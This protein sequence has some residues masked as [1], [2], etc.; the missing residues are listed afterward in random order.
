MKVSSMSF[1]SAALKTSELLNQ[2]TKRA[3]LI[4]DSEFDRSRIKRLNSKLEHPLI[5]EDVPDINSMNNCLDANAFDLIMVDYRLGQDN[6]LHALDMIQKHKLN[7]EA[8]KIMISGS[9]ET[10]VAVSALKRGYNDFV[11]KKELTPEKFQR[12]VYE[13]LKSANYDVKD[14]PKD[15]KIALQKA[16]LDGEVQGIVQQAVAAALAES[17]PSQPLYLTTYDQVDLSQMIL[18]LVHDEDDFIFR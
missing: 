3:L 2:K 13:A 8:A 17:E 4:D 6:G 15:I 18:D 12:S 14:T 7:K 1:H 16:L 9:A 5:L 11:S 10:E